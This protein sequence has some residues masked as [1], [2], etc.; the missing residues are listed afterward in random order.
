MLTEDA[1]PKYNERDNDEQRLKDIYSYLFMLVEQLRYSLGNL[2]ASNFNETELN[3]IG[4]G[5]TEELDGE[6]DLITKALVGETGS[7]AQILASGD[8]L[9]ARITDAEDK[10]TEA[11]M[12]VDGLSFK[13]TNGEQ[14]STLQL[15]SGATVLSSANIQITG[16]VTFLDLKQSGKTQING[17]NITTGTISAI[18]I[19]G[20]NITMY[21]DSDLGDDS[22]VT[23]VWGR[24]QVGSLGFKYDPDSGDNPY[25]ALKT[26]FAMDLVIVSDNEM[27][28][29]SED[30][31]FINAATI[32]LS[33]EDV[34]IYRP[35][36]YDVNNGAW[37]FSREGIKRNGVLHFPI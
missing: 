33:A 26:D 19:N 34:Y 23:F 36:L 32:T 24:R 20:C 37:T 10:A 9:L 7:I 8:A 13:V 5:I 18:D 2:G 27:H 17:S 35:T 3:L 12:T 30:G 31:M 11:I 29:N 14:S 22:S 4:E 6:V 28:I 16:M 25:V 1:L 21:Y 15:F